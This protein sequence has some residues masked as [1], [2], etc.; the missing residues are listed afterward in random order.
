MSKWSRYVKVDFP[1]P[2][3]TKFEDFCEGCT[4]ADLTASTNKFYGNDSTV[5]VDN[6][7]TCNNIDTCRRLFEHFKRA[8]NEIH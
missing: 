3:V 7:V 5:I 1:F 4:D 8:T 2:V 6:V